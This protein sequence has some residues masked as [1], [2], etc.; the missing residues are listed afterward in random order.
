M[1]IVL[2]GIGMLMRHKQED[3]FKQRI[4]DCFIDAL[5]LTAIVIF[6]SSAY[7][8]HFL[9]EFISVPLLVIFGGAQAY[10]E[11]DSR[12]DS[13][14]VA[15]F[16][17]GIFIIYG[18]IAIV[19]SLYNAINDYQVFFT[20]ETLRSFLLPILLLIFFVPFYYAFSLYSMYET[21][22]IQFKIPLRKDPNLAKYLKRKLFRYVGISVLKIEMLRKCKQYADPFFKSKDDVDCF[23][24]WIARDNISRILQRHSELGIDELTWDAIIRVTTRD[25]V[26]IV[27]EYGYWTNAFRNMPKG[28]SI[29]IIVDEVEHEIFVDE[30]STI[31][32]IGKFNT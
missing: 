5:S 20:T 4:K 31:E 26:E 3:S 14:K 25:R 6:V 2:S 28:E 29:Y 8:F 19:F 1:W 24:D 22:L 7:T 32:Q 27:G 10:A 30:I 9:V 18:A 15:K 13:K 11:N 16:L 17:Q 21:M 23:F 12:P